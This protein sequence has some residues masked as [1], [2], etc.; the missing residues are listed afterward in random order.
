MLLK[1]K[2]IEIFDSTLREG[3]QTPHVTFSFDQ[4]KEIINDL[5]NLGINFVE[6]GYPASSKNEF[7]EILKLTKLSKRP[8][9]SILSRCNEDDIK[10]C[11][12]IS[13][14]ILDIDLGISKFQL[15]YLNI[16]KEE[17]FKKANYITSIGFKTG[18]KIK[19]AALDFVR[20]PIKDLI[21]LYKIV[22]SAGAEWFTLC[23]TVGLATPDLIKY[24]F[25][26][27]NS[28]KTNCKI[29]VH[30]HN[31]FG[32]ATA[33]TITAAL[34]GADQL[35]VTLNGLGDRSGIASMAP[36]VTYLQE[37]ANF[38]L[39]ID[40]LNLK[41]ISEKIVTMTNINYSPL[42]PIVGEYCFMHTPGIHIA[43]ILK[44]NLTFEPIDPKKINQKREF[45]IGRY[46]GKHALQ[47]LLKKNSIIL[48]NE[49]TSILC[50]IIKNKTISL[51]RELTL[52]EIIKLVEN[53]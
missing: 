15:D 9:I 51:K 38:D 21:N 4:K 39:Q 41:S 43:G 6:V 18:K 44:N 33:N 1:N 7:N 19:F 8:Y 46:T 42:E 22:S 32:M 10:K 3:A 28:E 37:I 20:T 34:N 27:I 35:E 11:S 45:V 12:N 30:F 31:D 50:E 13:A 29:A 5:Y 48:N 23:D 17:A 52:E 26:K 36:V 14:E 24:F 40:L 16:T 2:K 25:K 47:F 49:Q 53:I